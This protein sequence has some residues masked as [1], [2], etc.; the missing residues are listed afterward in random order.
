MIDLDRGDIVQTGSGLLWRVLD[1][2]DTGA[3]RAIRCNELGETVAR[4]GKVH[5]L[6]RTHVSVIR[7]TESTVKP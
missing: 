4:R 7:R 6:K 2:Y 1:A 5:W 3:I